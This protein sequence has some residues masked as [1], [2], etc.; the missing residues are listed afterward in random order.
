MWQAIAGAAASGLIGGILNNQANA[1][2]SNRMRD[3]NAQEAQ[4]NRD[5]Q[6][7]MSNTAYQ[8]SMADMEKAGLNPMLA[9]SQGGAS[10]P[11]GSAA[12]GGMAQ[13]EN[14]LSPAVN[15]AMEARRL[16]KE[17]D[18]VDSQSMLNKQT[19]N[20]QAKQGAYLEAMTTASKLDAAKSSLQFQVMK[21]ESKNQIETI[22]A[23]R[24][25][26]KYSPILNL[27][28]K[29]TGAASNARDAISPR[30]TPVNPNPPKGMG[31]YRKSDGLI[32]PPR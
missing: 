11:G 26:L 4:W 19:A 27:I 8:R 20:T 22:K 15:S 14:V 21:E 18:A 29:V 28:N 6:E 13:M 5:F 30:F 10:T 9:Y 7:R 16:K 24:P 31:Y 25:Y 23:E 2:E 17:I 32:D 3:F 1:K 12:S